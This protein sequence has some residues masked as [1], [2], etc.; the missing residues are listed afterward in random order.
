MWFC[1]VFPC[2][3]AGIRFFFS[4]SVQNWRRFQREV[5][6]HAQKTIGTRR[7]K[8]FR[9]NWCRRAA[10]QWNR[11][12]VNFLFKW[13]FFS[14]TDR[15]VFKAHYWMGQSLALSRRT[16]GGGEP[17]NGRWKE[18]R[19]GQ[20]HITR[21]YF[22]WNYSASNCHTCPISVPV[23]VPD[24]R[25]GSLFTSPCWYVARMGWYLKM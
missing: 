24:G 19:Q 21:V 16:G 6:T 25:F 4:F 3:L 5:V 8:L 18:S 22:P 14:E 15:M 20:E 10:C 2:P 11:M 12:E 7:E 23:I 1:I 13:W 9:I 17:E